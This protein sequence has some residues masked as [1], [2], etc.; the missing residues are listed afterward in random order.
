MGLD[1]VT[2]LK[3]NSMMIFFLFFQEECSS[4]NAIAVTVFFF[5]CV[6]IDCLHAD[7]SVAL[8]LRSEMCLSL[9]ERGF[10]VSARYTQL[11]A[12]MG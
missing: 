11:R 5:C 8:R 12:Y 9:I 4:L 1:V 6:V 3:C 10:T 7:V 2:S